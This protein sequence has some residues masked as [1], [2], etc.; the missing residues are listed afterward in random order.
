MCE[1]SRYSTESCRKNSKIIHIFENSK[2][3]HICPSI[4]TSTYVAKITRLRK[5]E[6]AIRIIRVSLHW[7]L[8]GENENPSSNQKDMK[9]QLL[10]LINSIC[11]LFKEL[12]SNLHVI[13]SRKSEAIKQSISS[14][15]NSLEKC[16]DLFCD[17]I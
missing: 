8:M 14:F 5:Q 13:I 11:S 3:T 2:I 6:S 16:I 4:Y 1:E 10:S 7:Q 9:I 17:R 12:I 15:E